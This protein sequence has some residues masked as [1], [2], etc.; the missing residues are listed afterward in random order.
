VGINRKIAASLLSS[1]CGL[2]V[3]LAGPLAPESNAGSCQPDDMNWPC[4][5]SVLVAA[6]DNGS[7]DTNW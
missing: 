7:D 5:Q 2:V 4:A 6:G 3:L 1:A